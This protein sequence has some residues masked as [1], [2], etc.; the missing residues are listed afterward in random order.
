[1]KFIVKKL[2]LNIILSTT[3]IASVVAL[4]QPLLKKAEKQNQHEYN[5]Q[6]LKEQAIAS[7]LA[8]MPS[9]G[10]KNLISDYAF[11]KFLVY[12]GD[13]DIREHT[14]YAATTNLFKTVVKNDPQFVE[15]YFT[16]SPVNSIFAGEPKQSTALI[17][18]GL[19]SITPQS[20]PDSYFL[21][22]YK[23]IDELLFLGDSPAA[24]TSYD[25][26]IEWASY[27]DDDRS[28]AVSARM[29]VMSD[30]LANNPD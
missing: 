7:L 18:K 27:Y 5:R 8:R 1:M 12:F 25:R 21:W 19:E 22:I 2:V 14:G 3:L 16:M 17:A 13:H 20:H 24:K 15:A 11:L 10:F 29:K 26:G 23:A 9:F 28:R 6:E 30:F 4:Q